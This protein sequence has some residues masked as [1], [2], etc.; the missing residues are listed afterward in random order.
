M[1]KLAFLCLFLIVLKTLG[2]TTI[3]Q[4]LGDFNEIK[5]YNGIEVELIKSTVQKAEIS[6]AKAD[7]VTIKNDGKTLKI[8][9]K[10]PETLASDKAMV[11]LYYNKNIAI[12][13]GNEGATITGKD[14]NQPELEVKVQEGAF[15][16]LVVNTNYLKVK[17]SSGGVLKLS[18]TTKNQEVNVDL[19]GVYHGYKLLARDL[20]I[21]NAGSGAKA[22][23]N[24]GDILDLKVTFGGSIYYK[25]EPKSLKNKK[26]IGGIIEQRS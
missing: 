3:S 19:G 8:L 14:L 4:N 15:I 10:L 11:R 20:S 26:V 24:A 9:L 21:V 1:K 6:G 23:I 7:K 13:D 2:Q 18:G 12:I 22:E 17:A 16:N 5:V 25:G